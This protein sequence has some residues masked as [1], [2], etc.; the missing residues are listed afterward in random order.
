MFIKPR[1]AVTVLKSQGLA[2]AVALE[3]EL[4]MPWVCIGMDW[5][6]YHFHESAGPCSGTN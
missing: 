4:K 1:A 6:Q 5:Q 3:F 2:F